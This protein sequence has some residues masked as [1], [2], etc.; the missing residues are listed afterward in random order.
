MDMV[1]TNEMNRREFGKLAMAGAL[2]LASGAALNKATAAKEGDVDR[3]QTHLFSKCLQFMDYEEMSEAAVQMGFDGLDLTIR[4]GG[5]VEPV[6][7][8]EDLPKAVSTMSAHGLVSKM[9]VSRVTRVDDEAGIHSLK[10]ASELGYEYYRLGYYKPDKE[11]GMLANLERA[12]EAF[13][14]LAAFNESQG[15]HGAYQNHAGH[16]IG[17]YVTDIAYLLEGLHPRWAGCQYDVLHA[18]VEGGLAWPLGLRYVKDY[19]S[20]I[21]I[22]DFRWAKINGKWRVEDVPF[23]E[24][25]VDFDRYFKILRSYGARPLVSFHLEYD[26]GGAERG[27]REI[28]MP[29]KEI[30]AAIKRDLAR[31]HEAWAASAA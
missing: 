7:A 8:D 19:L 14:G 2:G 22:K 4:P 30:L 15:L 29:K 13:K 11:G 18:T 26:L 20:T 12:R 3:L 16:N 28:N 1:N 27:R 10:T 6:R 21:V 5:H 25:M 31:F 24:G 17:A 23:G 9:F